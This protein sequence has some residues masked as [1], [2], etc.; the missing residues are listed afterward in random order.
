MTIE[1]EPTAKATAAGVYDYFLGG[2]HYTRA[3]LQAAIANQQSVPRIAD[4]MRHNRDFLRRV[5]EYL[6]GQGVRQF[7]DIGSGYPSMG[8]VHEIAQQTAP[9]TRVV[10]ADYEP[11]T[12]DASRA[13]L[14]GNPNAIFIRGD[15]RAP[16]TILGNP[17]VRDLLDFDQPVALLLI[18][19][20][21]FLPGTSETAQLVQTYVGQLAPGSYLA[22]SHGT[23]PASRRGRERITQ[24]TKFYNHNVSEQF[25]LRERDEIARFFAG[26]T[27]IP[28]GL[29][30]TADW[31][32]DAAGTSA[33]HEEDEFAAM[34]A[35]GV[36]RI[37]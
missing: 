10:Y 23:T 22:I 1:N 3:D 26:T 2:T 31:N 32:P 17:E 12:V 8:N 37:G 25:Q 20:L 14:A 34:I 15:V 28:P 30:T 4:T 16:D 29:V 19:I 5:V 9:E 13:M 33:D 6:V 35:G 7:L 18:A 11:G 24:G 36:G 21:H 27:L